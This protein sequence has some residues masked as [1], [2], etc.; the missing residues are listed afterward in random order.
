MQ[1]ENFTYLHYIIDYPNGIIDYEHLKS[2]W[3]IFLFKYIFSYI[4]KVPMKV[5]KTQERGFELGF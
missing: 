3:I 5:T 4:G 2:K 1:F